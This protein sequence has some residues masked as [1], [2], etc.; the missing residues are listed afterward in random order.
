MVVG[1]H[2]GYNELSDVEIINPYN[3]TQ[4]CARTSNLPEA[5][6]GMISMQFDTSY[7]VCG[8]YFDGST[9][10]ECFKYQSGQWSLASYGLRQARGDASRIALDESTFW[11]TGGYNGP[12]A[13]Y[14][15]SEL[16]DVNK[17]MF[18]EG[19]VLP[20]KM[21]AQAKL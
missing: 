11:I 21:A 9:N 8:G 14:N 2:D 4:T 16:F 13:G 3:I 1:G 12:S 5:R 17:K 7:I 19:T 15:S 6:Y 10:K 20:Q 18:A